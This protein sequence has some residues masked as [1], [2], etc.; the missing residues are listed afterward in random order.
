MAPHA[1]TPFVTFVFTIVSNF[2]GDPVSIYRCAERLQPFE[3][4]QD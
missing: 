1:S 4:V 3:T 2:P